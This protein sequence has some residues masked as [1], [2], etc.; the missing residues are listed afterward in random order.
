MATVQTNNKTVDQLNS[1]LR[2]EISAVETYRLA[3][4]KLDNGSAARNELESC[5][6]SHEERVS[7]LR[8]MI[9]QLGGKPVDGSGAWGTFTKVVE[10]SAAAFG[11][12]VAISALEEGEDHGLRDYRTDLSKLEG[13]AR[14]IVV[15]ELLP[16]Q[17]QTHR[18]LSDLKH[19]IH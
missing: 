11:D 12:K 10:G 8:S 19:R 18:T 6:R 3:L 1:F 2:G 13:S 15:S 14:Q 4:K 9:Q 16:K 17:E 5:M 7:S